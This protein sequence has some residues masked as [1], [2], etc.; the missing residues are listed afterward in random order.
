MHWRGDIRRII[1]PLSQLALTALPKGEPRDLRSHNL[2]PPLGEVPRRGG[3]GFAVQFD[4]ASV[5][6]GGTPRSESK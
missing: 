1:N 5:G 4:S 2:P 3:E 6:E